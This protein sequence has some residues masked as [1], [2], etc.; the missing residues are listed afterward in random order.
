M[1]ILHDSLCAVIL[2]PHWR[3]ARISKACPQTFS[4]PTTPEAAREMKPTSNCAKR[5]CQKAAYVAWSACVCFPFVH[6][7]LVSHISKRQLN[8][9]L[10]GTLG[11]SV[12]HSHFQPA[13]LTI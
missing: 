10:D 13:T 1:A 8:H 3:H 7:R 2:L 9:L 5:Q 4:T 11:L 12:F 6:V